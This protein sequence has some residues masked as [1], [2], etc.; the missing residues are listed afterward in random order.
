MKSTTMMPPMS[1]RRSW[2]TISSA[3]SRLFLVT[4]SSRFP[5][6]PTNLPVLTSTTVMASVRSIT[7]EPPE[8]SHTLRSSAFSICS[9]MRNA[10]NGS[11]S[12]SYAS[13]RSSRSGATLSRYALI[14]RCDSSPWMSIFVKSSLKT[15]R[16]IFTSRSGSA[17]RSAGACWLSTCFWMC[18]HC[19]VRRCTSRVS[20][21][22]VAPSAAVRT[23]TPDD[24]GS[25]SLRMRLSRARSLSGSLRLMP[26]IEPPGTYTR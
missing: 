12:S 11:T 23:I 10:S 19:E 5:P 26:F 8:G 17:C 25:T 18:S 7:S 21:S 1:R 16:T 20:C 13:T 6:E 2:R 4:V 3:A 14:V 24:S 9:V 15:S 22:S